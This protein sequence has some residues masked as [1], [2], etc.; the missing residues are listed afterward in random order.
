[1]LPTM[2]LVHASKSKEEPM[3]PK[4]LGRAPGKFRTS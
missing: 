3:V 1:M 4:D 2:T